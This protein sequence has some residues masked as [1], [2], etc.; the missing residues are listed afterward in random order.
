M[1]YTRWSLLMSVRERRNTS[2]SCSINF[3]TTEVI[4]LLLAAVL[5]G[6]MFFV[7]YE[8]NIVIAFLIGSLGLVL[9]ELGHKVVGRYFCVRNA[10]FTI[11]FFGIALGF[12]TTLFIGHPVTTPGGVT[13]SE[14]SNQKQKLYMALGGPVTNYIMFFIF[15]GLSV[16]S[17]WVINMSGLEFDV[18]M[19]VALINLF[20]GFFNLLPIPGFDGSWILSYNVLVWL[21]FFSIG[22]ASLYFLWGDMQTVVVP[23]FNLTRGGV[24][25]FVP[26]IGGIIIHETSQVQLSS[27][28]LHST[29]DREREVIG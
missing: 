17:P 21:F 11:S 16:F 26:M 25:D 7:A 8:W 18:W 27:F 5:L 13:V 10:H 19:S 20:L 28:A 14:G 3:T 1:E 6:V 22:L 15:F 29:M 2:G 23:L 4:E 9:H 12:V 24:T